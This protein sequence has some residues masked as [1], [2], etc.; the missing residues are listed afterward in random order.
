MVAL[1]A[2]CVPEIVNKTHIVAD[3]A[4]DQYTSAAFNAAHNFIQEFFMTST[5][6]SLGKIFLVSFSAA[7]LL[8]CNM[9]DSSD[10]LPAPS[11]GNITA[12]EPGVPGGVTT[13]IVKVTALVSDIDY[14][15]RTVT[16]KNDRGEKRTLEVSPQAVNFNNVKKGDIVTVEMV[17]ELAIYLRDKNAPASDDKAGFIAKAPPGEKPAVL[18]ADSAEKTAVVKAVDLKNHTATLQFEN[19]SSKVVNVRKDVVLNKNQIGRTV[20]FRM[21]TAMAIN[22]Q[23]PE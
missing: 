22:V 6:R 21:T 2:I 7:T 18:I 15:N 14:K 9:N 4:P 1:A 11:A 3:C 12:M 17:E 5:V 10:K 20:V 16:L 8:A 19:G 13:S 23:K